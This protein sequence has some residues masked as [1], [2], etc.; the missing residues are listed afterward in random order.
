[1]E[2]LYTGTNP[3]LRRFKRR[4]GKLLV[5]HGWRDQSVIPFFSLDYHAIATRAMAGKRPP[6][7]FIGYL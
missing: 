6:T 7:S 5:Y 1:M 3:D 4:G 2:R